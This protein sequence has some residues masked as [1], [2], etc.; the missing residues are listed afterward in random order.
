MEL[1]HIATLVFL[2]A[3][4]ASATSQSVNVSLPIAYEAKLLQAVEVPGECP[5]FNQRNATLTEIKVEIARLI[6]DYV[7]PVLYP[8]H[9]RWTNCTNLIPAL[10]W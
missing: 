8:K 9:I 10:L 7:T 1:A 5:A 2:S 6:Q 4:A 3:Y